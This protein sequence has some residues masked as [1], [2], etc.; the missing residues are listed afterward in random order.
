MPGIAFVTDFFSG[1]GFPLSPNG[2]AYYRC[3]LPSLT[4]P[5]RVDVGRPAWTGS[6]G[7]GVVTSPASA[8]FFYDTVVLKGLMGRNTTFQMKAAQNLGQ[9]IIVDIDDWAEEIPEWSEAA[10]LADSDSSK[11][12]N[13]DHLREVIL[14]ADV[15]I[16]STPFLFDAYSNIRGNVRLVRNSINADAMNVRQVKNVKPVLGWVGHM[17]KRIGDIESLRGWLPHFLEDHDLRFHHSGHVDDA[18][19]FAEVAGIDPM[20]VTTSPLMKIDGYFRD[21]FCF[22]IGLVPM[23]DIPF[24]HAKSSLKGLEYAASGIPFVAQDL[25]EYRLLATSGVGRVASNHETWRHQLEMLLDFKTRKRE[26]AVNLS[27]VK[28]EHTI[29]SRADEWRAALLG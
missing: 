5:G 21:S 23:A 24:N 19:S 28:R 15:V 25:P 4:L 29:N 26:A 10:R 16:T 14:Q 9:R 3:V 8:S 12:F 20:R 7:F 17:G 13:T 11:V 2:V 1:E 22:D 27:N 6:E 18:P